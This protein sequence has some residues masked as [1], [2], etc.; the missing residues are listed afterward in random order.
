MLEFKNIDLRFGEELVLHHFN[1]TIKEHD[2][3]VI[4][5]SSGIGKSTIINLILGFIKADAGQIY[6]KG[7]LVTDDTIQN[8]RA[9]VAWLPQEFMFGTGSVEDIIKFPFQF[10]RNKD[11]E[12]N[13]DKIVR[14]LNSLHLDQSLLSKKYDD[15]S[16]GQ[17][18]RVGLAL[19]LLLERSFILLDEP[20]S[21]L[22]PDSRK[23]VIDLFLNNEDFTVLST[24]HDPEWIKHCSKVIDLKE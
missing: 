19:C 13:G 18:Q 15:I 23:C 21:S 8:V 22:D 6:W 11:L 3:T 4:R 20:T 16:E 17:K 14:I 9:S 2:K 12:H 1:M 10:S 24:S 7:A 5:G